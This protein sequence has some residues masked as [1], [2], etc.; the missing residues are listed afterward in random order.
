[1][2]R[3]KLQGQ[4]AIVSGAGR[5]LGAATA[6]LLAR[7]GA[8]VMLTA[9]GEDEVQSVAASLRT[10]GL[11]ATA[12]PADVSDVEQLENVVQGAL[13]EFGRVDILVN[14]AAII[15]PLEPIV[16]TDPEEWAYTILTN[17]VGPLNLTRYALPFMLEKGFGRIVNVSSERGAEAD[18]RGQ[19]L[20]R[21]Q[22]RP[23][24]AHPHACA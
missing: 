23:R 1:M 9:R 15:W 3:K 2:G 8:A 6:S 17:L 12:I 10:E 21:L 22:S 11:R 18:C 5:G 13:D 24:H 16:E 20:L 19:R 4:V 7:A 14:N